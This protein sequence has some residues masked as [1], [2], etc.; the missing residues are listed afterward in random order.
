MKTGFI[1]IWYDL[2]RKMFYIG[3]HQGTP[4]DGYTGSNTRFKRAISKRPLSFKRRILEFVSFTYLSELHEREQ[5]WLNFIKEED[6]GQKYYNIRKLAR[7][8]SH[9]NKMTKDGKARL[10]A[11]RK[12]RGATTPKG[13]VP[14]VDLLG[15]F[16]YVSRDEYRANKGNFGIILTGRPRGTKDSN[17]TKAKKRDYKLGKRL[18][19]TPSG[20][21]IWVD[22]TAPEIKCGL[23]IPVFKGLPAGSFTHSLESKAAMSARAKDRVEFFC[24]CCDKTIKGQS[25]INRHLK[26]QRHKQNESGVSD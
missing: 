11:A 10:A 25:N 4:D 6:L 16:K 13:M 23:F 26:S 17:E 15:T 5:H 21:S 2:I 20:E 12:E 8:G 1:Y 14:V 24:P 3:S 22:S 7:G 19:K 18:V 9:K